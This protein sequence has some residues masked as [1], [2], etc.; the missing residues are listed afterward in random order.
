MN[1]L[2]LLLAVHLRNMAIDMRSASRSD[3][4]ASIAS[5]GDETERRKRLGAWD[6]QN[7][8]NRFIP[9]ALAEVDAIA[10]QVRDLLRGAARS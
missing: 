6:R 9:A 7:P 2:E 8:L 1:T 5:C 3:F 4:Y 10:D